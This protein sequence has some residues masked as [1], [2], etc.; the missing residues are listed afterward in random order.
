MTLAGCAQR[1]ACH[2]YDLLNGQIQLSILTQLLQRLFQLRL[3]M[4]QDLH[5]VGRPLSKVCKTPFA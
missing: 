3:G 1:G 5:H 4:G 2:R